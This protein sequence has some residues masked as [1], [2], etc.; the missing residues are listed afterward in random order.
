MSYLQQII[1]YMYVL[2][3][4]LLFQEDV[5]KRLKIADQVNEL[6]KPGLPGNLTKISNFLLKNFLS[7]RTCIL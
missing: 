7:L 5:S 2:L 6:L 3:I 4:K 1:I